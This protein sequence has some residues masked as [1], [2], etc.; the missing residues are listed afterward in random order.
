MLGLSG[1]WFAHLRSGRHNSIR[2]TGLREQD[3]GYVKSAELRG[4]HRES[5][6]K[7]EHHLM[8]PSHTPS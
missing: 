4:Q 7:P 5:I 6:Q 2:D 3:K 1:L 8:L